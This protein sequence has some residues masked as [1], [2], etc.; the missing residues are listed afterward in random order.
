MGKQSVDAET[1]ELVR[2]F[3]GLEGQSSPSSTSGCAA[4]PSWRS[5]ASSV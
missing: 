1:N 3:A 4:S 5:L 2:K